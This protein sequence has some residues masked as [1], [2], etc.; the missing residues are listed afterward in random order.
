ME[1]LQIDTL[2]LNSHFNICRI[3]QVRSY[4]SNLAVNV[5]WQHYLTDD[6]DF[7]QCNDPCDPSVTLK[8]GNFKGFGGEMLDPDQLR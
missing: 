8:D 2:N 5:W 3:H 1:D 7:T 4:G 6:L